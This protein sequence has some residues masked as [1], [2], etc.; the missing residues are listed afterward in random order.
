MHRKYRRYGIS[1][2][3]IWSNRLNLWN[4]DQK[5]VAEKLKKELEKEGLYK[6]S[7]VTEITPFKNFYAAENYHKDYYKKN[8][9]A[10]YCSFVIDPKV[11]KL[12]QNYGIDVK[13]EYNL[14][15]VSTF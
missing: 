15:I 3:R 9:N 14:N 4:Q 10:P 2:D 8:R 11:H 7:I 12:L 5:K 1:S 13:E 6:D